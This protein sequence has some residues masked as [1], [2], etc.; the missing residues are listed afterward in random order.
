MPYTQIEKSVINTL[1]ENGPMGI[2]SL[3]PKVEGLEGKKQLIN[4]LENLQS[5]GVT[6]KQSNS[7]WAILKVIYAQLQKDGD[8]T[9]TSEK[10]PSP[11]KAPLQD[12]PA[13]EDIRVPPKT[14]SGRKTATKL[15]ISDKVL[16][17]MS[18]L[19][20]GASL[21]ISSEGIN[22]FWNQ[23]TLEPNAEELEEVMQSLHCLQ[24]CVA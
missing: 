19:P 7:Q 22:L 17:M 2:A 23:V 12:I 18:I 21:A 3:M 14:T 5:R 15:S 10:K 20:Q 4:V 24:R 6:K 11:K 9:A 8:L 13:T 1:G 16:E